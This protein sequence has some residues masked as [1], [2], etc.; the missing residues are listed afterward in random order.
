[1]KTF[2]GFARPDGSVGIR[3]HVLIMAVDECAE[4]IAR[5]IADK[6]SNAVVV[7]N[8][9]TC[10]YG[11]NEEM[12]NTMTQS[13][14]NPNVAGAL[15]LAMGCGSIDP[16]IV[17]AP[18][19][20]TGRPAYSLTCV[21]QKGT[22]AT[23]QEGLELAKQL[24]AYAAGVERVDTPVSELI[25]GVKCGGSDTSSGIASNP[26]VGR[27]VDM[28][29]EDGM[30]AVAGELIELIGC[31]D[32]L[33]ERAV[34]E[35]V[36]DKIVRLI[37]EEE[38]RW[39]IE[40]ADV[41][42][43]SIGNSVGGLTTLEEKSLGALHKTGT[44]AIQDVLQINNSGHLK[45]TKPGMYL[46][47]VTHLCGG[48]GMHFAALGTHMVLWTTGGA[49]FNNAIVPVIRVSGNQ[50][51]INEDIDI[52]ATGIMRAEEGIDSVA[53]RIVDKVNAVAN[54]EQTNIEEI[55]Y[56]YCSLYQKDQ[57]L[58][59]LLSIEPIPVFCG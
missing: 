51:L 17:S 44:C 37:E 48:A 13:G 27:A 9:N 59:R 32:I 55:G 6:I 24:E 28:M 58:E 46:S 26:S 7:T 1:M 49:G 42:T 4:G 5:A 38:K 30:T 16:E 34:S 33:R 21:K 23:I 8:Y 29:V 53:N 56:A 57:R 18:I 39:H 50:H 35:E 41:E 11:G 25:V 52:D 12:I 54:G 2:K 36:A 43:M 20:A 47:E 14:I 19:R 15:V 45:P 40:G 10:M 31:E 22:R 3:N